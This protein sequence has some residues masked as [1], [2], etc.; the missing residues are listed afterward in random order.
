MYPNFYA[1]RNKLKKIVEKLWK[2]KKSKRSPKK[3]S[4]PQENDFKMRLE[5]ILESP[6]H[7][8]GGLIRPVPVPRKKVMFETPKA[9]QPSTSKKMYDDE[10]TSNASSF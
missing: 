8:P 2:D 1:T 7:K 4:P 6:I 5:K 10:T 9:P 3:P